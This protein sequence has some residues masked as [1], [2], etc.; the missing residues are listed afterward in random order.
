MKTRSLGRQ[1]A[2]LPG[3]P[4]Q[5]QQG[6]GDFLAEYSQGKECHIMGVSTRPLHKIPVS[7]GRMLH[8]RQH[9]P[10]LWRCLTWGRTH[11]IPVSAQHESEQR[12]GLTRSGESSPVPC[13]VLVWGCPWRHQQGSGITLLCPAF[14]QFCRL[15][16]FARFR[17]LGA[18]VC[19]NVLHE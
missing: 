2:P 12:S 14:P 15:C 8:V 18:N 10:V 16:G 4:R 11:K 13:G 6:F 1:A 5:Q 9:F 7:P 17:L 3:S 19:P